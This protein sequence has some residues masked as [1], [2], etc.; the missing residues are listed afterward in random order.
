MSLTALAE[1]LCVDRANM[2]RELKEMQSDGLIMRKG[3]HI[4]L[5]GA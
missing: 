1:Y 3:K 5:L 4:T 2:M